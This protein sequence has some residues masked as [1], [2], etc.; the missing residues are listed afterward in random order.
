M[1]R[2]AVDELHA[3]MRVGRAVVD[4]EGRVLLK[5]GTELRTSYIR[6]LR[7]L[8]IPAVYVINELAPD[9]EPPDVVSP[10]TR[11]LVQGELRQTMAQMHRQL[12]DEVK[13]GMR[14]FILPD[15]GFR[16]RAAVGQLVDELAAN[17][18]VVLNCHDIRQADAY[19][20]GHSVSVCIM[21][22]LVGITL[23]YDMSRLADLA[24]GCLLHDVGKVGL[25]QTILQKGGDLTQ[26]E[27]QEIRRHPEQGFAVLAAQAGISL[28][29][30]HVAL[31]HHERWDGRGYPRGLKG[32]EIHE[33][34]RICAIV[35]CYDALVTDRVYRKGISP[36]RALRVLTE[37]SFG[38]FDPNL[39]RAFV[40]NIAPFPVGS[41][42]QLS[43]GE[44][45]VVLAVER[46]QR[47][48]PR[49]RVVQDGFGQ[50]LIA[51]YEL[52]LA[53]ALDMEIVRALDDDSQPEAWEVDFAAG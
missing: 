10:L 39:L 12:S 42:V 32:Q 17:R 41:M 20:L 3:G 11:A 24:V 19:T 7:R 2:L 28:V 21:S 33:Y 37:G 45:A 46:H 23:G 35:D 14:A 25:P 50:P 38:F 49:V 4:P 51:P 29:S 27:M 15:D 31:Q 53:E 43:S 9:I 48:R 36:G 18:S 22:I 44:V 34:A 52:N 5:A 30:A 8:G 13:K 6:H 26:Q 47:S 1:L 16:V 40:A